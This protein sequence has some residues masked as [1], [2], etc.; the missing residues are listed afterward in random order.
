MKKNPKNCFY[1][2]LHKFLNLSVLHKVVLMQ[3]WLFRIG[4]G[5]RN[6]FS[7]RNKSYVVTFYNLFQVS[8]DNQFTSYNRSTQKTIFL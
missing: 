2:E 5:G 8:N 1:L 6:V 7:I 3:D 4:L